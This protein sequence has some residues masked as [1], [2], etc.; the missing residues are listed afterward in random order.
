MTLLIKLSLQR[1]E[2]RISFHRTG[3]SCMKNELT[4]MLEIIHR[5]QQKEISFVSL[6]N[7][8]YDKVFPLYDKLPEGFFDCWS[9]NWGFLDATI[10]DE[11]YKPGIIQ[12]REKEIAESI[13]EL[14]RCITDLIEKN[15]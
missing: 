10:S 1:S 2:I 6:V 3:E 8:L 5:Y 11:D 13:A 15:G 9:H 12:K 14:V 7:G 4:Q